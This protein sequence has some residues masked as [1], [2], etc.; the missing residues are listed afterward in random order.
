MTEVKHVRINTQIFRNE[1][2]FGVLLIY[3]EF[4]EL[5]EEGNIE[6]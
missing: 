5:K 2:I 4:M 1:F 6:E 3:T